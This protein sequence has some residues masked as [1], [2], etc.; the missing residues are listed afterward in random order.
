MLFDRVARG[1]KITL[2][3]AEAGTGKTYTAAAIAT[4][5]RVLCLAPTWKAIHVLQ[6]KL[7]GIDATL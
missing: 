1:N 6:H 2:C 7:N 4:G 3:C 5:Q